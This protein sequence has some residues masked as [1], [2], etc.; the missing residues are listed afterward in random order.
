MALLNEK[1]ALVTSSTRGI[2]YHTAKKLASKGAKV[3]LA[4]RRLDAGKKIAEEIQQCG[5]SA[6]V[7]YF[8]AE[9]EQTYTSMI[10]EVLQKENRIDVLV[11]N[12]GTTDVQKDLDVV[13][14][15]TDKFFDIVNVNIK[16]VYLPCKAVIPYM[17]KNGGGS[18]INISSVG[19][20]YADISRTAYGVS[21]AAINFLTKDI[22]V[23]YAHKNIRCN[24]VLP[25]F[26]ET[27]ASMDN[28]SQEFLNMFLKTVPLGK[29]G[30]PD[31]IA[32]AVLYFASDLSA[33]V[34]G[35]ILSISGGFGVSSPMYPL[36]K[37]MMKKG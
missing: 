11:N 36:Y 10:Q 18:I 15:D 28:M 33:F 25:G 12:F 16:S 17:E 2:G 6:D 26:I 7:V 3:Y 13:R 31:D 22:A 8:D 1:V 37:D 32:N 9:K 30:Q 19:G 4:V 23:Q 35:E 34:T 14:G 27:D 21:K 20:K 24:A 29:S 5:D